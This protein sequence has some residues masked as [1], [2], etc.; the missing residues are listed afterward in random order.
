VSVEPRVSICEACG[1]E[2]VQK[3]PYHTM[4]TCS[5]ECRYKLSAKSNRESSGRWETKVC[6]CGVEFQSAVAKPKTYH[7]WDCMMKHRIE[8]SRATRT[9]EVCGNEFTHFKRQ[10]QRTCSPACRN[11]LTA[12]QRE[13][14]YPEC[15]EC[16]VST[17]SYNRIYCDE[18]RPNRPGRKALP[19]K[20]ATCLGCGEEFSRPGSWPGKM[21]YCS[22][23]CSH[24]EVKSVRDKF[25]LN[26]ND[27]AIVFHSLWEVRFVAVCARLDIDWRRYDG[28]DIETS[29]GVY[30]PDFI[31]GNKPSEGLT[32]EVKGWEDRPGTP[33]KLAESGVL[34]IGKAHLEV[35]EGCSY[36]D[37]FWRAIEIVRGVVQP[38]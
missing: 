26:L 27:K 6:P 31:I 5:K 3:H 4:K 7:D 34:V 38:A 24:S 16:G 8:E 12:A 35:L 17:G 13:V 25:V 9:C 1:G 15:R 18:H 14:N 30:R 11:K 2:F 36:A 29:Q 33:E 32:V 19:R 23:K 37:T 21:N 28:P 22:N 10:D 20:T